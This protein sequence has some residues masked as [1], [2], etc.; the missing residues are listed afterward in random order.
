MLNVEWIY[1]N[2]DSLRATAVL[3]VPNEEDFADVEDVRVALV[4][5]RP[6]D[7]NLRDARVVLPF[8][9]HQTWLDLVFNMRESARC[10]TWRVPA[11]PQTNGYVL[12]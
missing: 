6:P 11:Q 2:L 12:T 7:R 4:H 10:A 3:A 5:R 9:V 1:T 8:N